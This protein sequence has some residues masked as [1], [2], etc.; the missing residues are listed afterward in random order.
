M[1]IQKNT[2]LKPIVLFI[3]SGLLA[4][5]SGGGSTQTTPAADEPPTPAPPASS[6]VV[7]L[8]EAPD[9]LYP[10]GDPNEAAQ[11]VLQAV[12][13]APVDNR[14]YDYQPVL[15][16]SVPSLSAGTAVFQTVEVLPGDRVVDTEGK[17][18]ELDFGTYVRP[19]GCYG[20]DCAVA[21]DGT[22]I[23]MDQMVVLFDLLP[24]LT[25]ADGTPL[26]AADSAYGYT[27]A[28]DANSPVDKTKVERTL[29]YEAINDTQIKWTGIPGFIDHTYMANVWTPAPAHL[30]GAKSPA[31]LV[32]APEAAQTPLGYGPY[33]VASWSGERVILRRNPAY[34]RAGEGRPAV[35]E[36]AFQVVG[37]DPDTN[38]AML[39]SGEC[40]VLDA[41]AA[42]DLDYADLQTRMAGGELTADW[43]NGDGWESISIGIVPS[44]YDD[45]YDYYAGDR[46]NFFGDPRTRQA[47]AQCID[48]ER[49]AQIATD[50]VAPVMDTYVPPD[51]PLFN[52]DTP[53]YPYNP[54]A[55]NQLLDE[56]GWTGRNPQGM[57]LVG[58]IPGLVNS[59]SFSIDYF[60][61]DHPQSEAI[62]QVVGQN[63]RECG[64]EVTLSSGSAEELF[65][66]GEEGLLFRR[67][68]DLAQ[69]PWQ[70]ADEPICF[71]YLGDAVPGE[72]LTVFQYGWG[73]WNLTGWQNEAFDAACKAT[74][75]TAPGLEAFHQ[76]HLAAQQVFAEELP[77]IPLFAYQEVAVARPDICGF[78]FDPTAGFA[79]NIENLAYGEFCP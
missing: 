32:S 44:S 59:T 9:T 57:R 25:W 20:S 14:G 64:I 66:S 61:L 5:C 2:L 31:E 7:C 1:R 29:A 36:I 30:W 12:F 19:A 6:L 68:F 15:L 40:D 56:V 37:G 53:R 54:A 24:G 43:A 8:G 67:Q 52:P 11:Q 47:I 49:I 23:S 50:G 79:W 73:G 27:L 39:L 42:Q 62:A 3:L 41:A 78:D 48:R 71:L 72:D 69:F 63:L 45:G 10:Y 18:V 75:G 28:A 17:V 34:F 77:V 65:Q 16:Q 13:E 33:T 51:H 26:T 38:L 74:Q 4:A 70:S 35:E 46:S 21:F 55:A 60:F 76:N 58:A 22:R